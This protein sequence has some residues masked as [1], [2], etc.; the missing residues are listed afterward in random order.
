MP[1]VASDLPGIV[2]IA[3]HFPELVRTLSLDRSDATWLSAAETLLTHRTP[4]SGPDAAF[5]STP[6]RLETN[7]AA[8]R[9]VWQV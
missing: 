5:A 8:L 1:V 3:A 4:T 7:L 6:F 2:E 9:R